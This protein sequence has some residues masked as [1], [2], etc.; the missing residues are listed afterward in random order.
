[1]KMKGVMDGKSFAHVQHSVGFA[2]DTVCVVSVAV[3]QGTGTAVCGSKP[4][5]FP[6]LRHHLQPL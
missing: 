5:L 1:M 2:A 4:D 3:T 6:S